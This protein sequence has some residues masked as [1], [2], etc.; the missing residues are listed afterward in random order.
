MKKVEYC[1]FNPGGNVTALVFNK[2]YNTHKKK[3]I[4]NIILSK[5]S[6]VE[7]VGFIDRDQFN[8]KMAGGE[9][10]GNATRCAVK[11]YLKDNLGKEISIKVSG[12]GERLYSGMGSDN[13]IWVDIPVKFVENTKYNGINIV[14][15]DGITHIVF[16]EDQ[17]KKYL[18]D[19]E[20]LKANAKKIIEE[21]KID[22]SA[23]GVLFIERDN[24][25][26]K[27][28]PIVWVKEIDTEHFNE[29]YNEVKNNFENEIEML[30]YINKKIAVSEVAG[31]PTGGAV[32]I[33]IFDEEKNI[34]ID[35]GSKILDCDDEKCYYNSDEISDTAKEN[36]KLLREVMTNEGF[37]P[38]NGEWWHF[39]YGDKEWAF[40]YGKE[41][42]LYNQ[43]GAIEVYGYRE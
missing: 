24:E 20:K 42:A 22:D 10:C 29:I 16:D 41:K 40:Y 11:Y 4:N 2:Y 30:E 43:I 27:L 6:E 25:T 32:D 31:H 21:F 13:N 5:H 7:Q 15:L 28:Y 23:V 1:I 18:K 9:F 26:I 12:M 37:A 19:K 33:A 17:S 8:L 38:F 36:R 14:K 34:I 39:S 3:I 35:F